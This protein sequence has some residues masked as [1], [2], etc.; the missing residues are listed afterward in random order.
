MTRPRQR[1]KYVDP[2]ESHPD[3]S[4]GS[5]SSDTDRSDQTS[6]EEQSER[7]RVEAKE[8]GEIYDGET[9]VRNFM[10]KRQQADH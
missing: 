1:P 3:T 9:A 2:E 4:G 7:G 8:D 6:D 5:D 10:A